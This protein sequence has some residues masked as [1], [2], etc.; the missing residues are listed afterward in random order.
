MSGLY[1]PTALIC[2]PGLTCDLKSTGDDVGT[3]VTITSASIRQ[4]AAPV[5]APALDDADDDDDDDDDDDN[6]ADDGDDDDDD[7]D[8]DDAPGVYSW[9][10]NCMSG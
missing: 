9:H 3:A 1:D 10:E 4:A 7:D 2:T 5:A 6:D 8:D